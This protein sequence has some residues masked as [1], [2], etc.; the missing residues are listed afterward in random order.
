M[1]TRKSWRNGLRAAL[2]KV[3]S[4]RAR[5]PSTGEAASKGFSRKADAAFRAQE[6]NDD[7]S[8]ETTTH[9]RCCGSGHPWQLEKDVLGLPGPRFVR[10]HPA[11]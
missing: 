4:R 10:L 7:G 9:N 8:I 5:K 6:R 2:D 11:I 1:T 3:I